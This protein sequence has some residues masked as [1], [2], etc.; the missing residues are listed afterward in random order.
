MQLDTQ[1]KKIAIIAA[2]IA[3]VLLSG[4]LTVFA[5]KQHAKNEQAHQHAQQ[6]AMQAKRIASAPDVE[7][8]AEV[9]FNKGDLT[10]A[11]TKYQEASALYTEARNTE[12]VERTQMQIS[13][14]DSKLKSTTLE[15]TDLGSVPVDPK[16]SAERGEPEPISAQ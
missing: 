1:K 9:L 5:L 15:P 2:S 13:L 7:K 12:G 11:K 4:M 16:L 3:V 14:I 6:S 10:A 8:E